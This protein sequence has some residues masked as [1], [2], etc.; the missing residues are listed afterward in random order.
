MSSGKLSSFSAF[1]NSFSRLCS[2]S[3]FSFSSLLFACTIR[4]KRGQLPR[5]ARKQM[6]GIQS[7]LRCVRSCLFD[8][9][10]QKMLCTLRE[11]K[12]SERFKTYNKMQHIRKSTQ[13]QLYPR[14]KKSDF[15]RVTTKTTAVKAAAQYSLTFES[16]RRP[17]IVAL[18][19]RHQSPA[20]KSKKPF[21]A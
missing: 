6:L 13:L 16:K 9:V 14:K 3:A 19:P 12:I 21:A 18:L 8:T 17:T 11:A 4:K 5:Y 1:L 10:M 20:R 7:L 15:P 2:L